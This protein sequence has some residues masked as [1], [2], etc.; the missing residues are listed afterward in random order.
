MPFAARRAQ[1]EPAPRMDEH[2]DPIHLHHPAPGTSRRV[3]VAAAVVRRGDRLLLTQ[4]PPGGPLGLQWELPGGKIEEGESPEH[5]LV[6][7]LREELGVGARPHEV[8]QVISHDYAHGLEVEIVFVRCELDS[9][10]FT[11]SPAVHA[12]RWVIP[13]EIDLGQVLAADREFLRDLGARD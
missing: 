11:P 13:S 7:E 2:R 12:A 10:E 6:R 4:R 8:L 5:A 3:R 1:C 9:F